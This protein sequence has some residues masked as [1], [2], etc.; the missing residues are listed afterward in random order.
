VSSQLVE[1]VTYSCPHCLV[2][3]EAPAGSWDGWVRCSSC[4]RT[5]LPPA[6][7]RLPRGLNANATAASGAIDHAPINDGSTFVEPEMEAIGLLT[8]RQTSTSGARLVF[9]T[10]LV[11]CGFLSLI[12]FLVHEPGKLAIFGGLTIG[13][14]LLLLRSPRKRVPP[15]EAS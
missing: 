7:E 12:F 10:G 9:I 5:F 2:E 3:L 13:F 11:L 1:T 14:F 15:V 8:G 4:A 6:P